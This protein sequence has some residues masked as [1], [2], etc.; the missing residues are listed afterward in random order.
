MRATASFPTSSSSGTARGRHAVDCDQN[1]RYDPES[2][3][4]S[5]WFV[6]TG[7]RYDY[8]AVPP[9]TVAAFRDAFS[10]GRFFNARIRDRFRYREVEDRER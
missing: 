6:P 7:K 5:V 4:L 3:T 1:F 2:R 10:K 9:Q 8:E